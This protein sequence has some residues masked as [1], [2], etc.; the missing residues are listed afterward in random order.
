MVEIRTK[1]NIYALLDENNKV[2]YVGKTSKE[3][4]IRLDR[5]C[6]MAR[7]GEKIIR[8]IGLGRCFLLD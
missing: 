1:T 8:V 2:R 7:Y 5:H 4:P 6:V 3:L